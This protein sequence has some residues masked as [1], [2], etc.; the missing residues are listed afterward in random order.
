MEQYYFPPIAL[1]GGKWSVGVV[2]FHS[3]NSVPNIDE[4]NNLIKIGPHE[5]QIPTG[6]YEV[7]EINDYLS[8][9]LKRL[10]PNHTISI[11]GN[12]NT[13]KTEVKSSLPVYVS[14]LG[15]LLGFQSKKFLAANVLHMS[16]SPIQINKVTDVRIECNI[17]QGNYINNQKCNSIFGFDINVPPGY[18]LSLSPQTVIYYPIVVESIDCLL[19]QIVDQAG[20]LLN[21][22]SED[23]V[24]RLHLKR[25]P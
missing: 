7:E 13:L 6:A 2:D 17:A 5:I 16:D 14:T 12:S 24:I 22:R 21:F 23:I 9:E 4:S 15:S 10:D 20:N 3:Y 11:Q 25:S 18:K 1:E 8:S 19:V